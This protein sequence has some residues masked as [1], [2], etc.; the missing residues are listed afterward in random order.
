ML[1]SKEDILKYLSNVPPV[2][3]NVQKALLYLNNGDIKNAAI[4]AE[5]DFVLKKQIERVINSAYYSLTKKVD[6]MVQ[7][8]TLLG[9]EK[10]RSLIYSYLVSLL[11]P[12]KWKIFKINFFDFQSAFMKEFEEAMFLEFNEEIYKKYVEIGAIIPAAVCVCDSLLGDKKDEVDILISSA[13]LEYSTL[14]KRMSGFSL[15]E[16]ASKIAFLW[17]LDDEKIEILKKSECQ[18]C[19]EKLP[20][21]IHFVFFMLVSKKEFLDI[22]SL[23]AFN[24][25]C[26]NLIPKINERMMNDS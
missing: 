9:I 18:K 12:K 24:P 22:N 19:N 2:P 23:I 6:N 11:E 7:L 14:I 15:F 4:E 1:I 16:I 10:A 8:F 3:E 25:E 20:A 17:G 26:I 5:K 13:P 21:L